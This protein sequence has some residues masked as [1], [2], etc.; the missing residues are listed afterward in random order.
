MKYNNNKQILEKKKR[1]VRR[2][3]YY[4]ARIAKRI[5]C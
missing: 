5:I 4:K 3:D 2:I 1:I